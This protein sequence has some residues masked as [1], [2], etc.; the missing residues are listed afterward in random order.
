MH[1]PVTRLRSF[2][3]PGGEDAARR[4]LAVRFREHGEMRSAPQAKWTSFTAETVLRADRSEF[5]WD[6]R[7]SGM[8]VVDAY[9]GG[10]G[11]AVLKVARLVPVK[12]YSGPETDRGE[13]LRY[14][15][16]AA[17]CPSMMVC[18]HAMGWEP[19]GEDLVRV[20][21]RATGTALDLAIGP[22]GCP[23]LLRAVR[24]RMAGKA[25]I[26]TP[27]SGACSDFVEWEGLRVATRVDA[28]W[29]LPEG[30]FVYYRAEVRGYAIQESAMVNG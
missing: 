26:P 13:L 4:I 9:E 14:L 3:L 17:L 7:F 16:S 19:A 5:C 12:S 21:D 6:A 18:N 15:G 25:L 1:D 28:R 30:E 8:S 29:T 20:S 24:H 23:G 27:W 2:L 10:R 22:D 11:R